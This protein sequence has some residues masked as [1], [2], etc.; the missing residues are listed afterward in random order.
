MAAWL[1]CGFPYEACWQ[2]KTNSA[3]PRQSK[4]GSRAKSAGPKVGLRPTRWLGQQVW[5]SKSE[6]ISNMFTQNLIGHNLT[7]MA[8]QK[9]HSMP[10]DAEFR[11][12]SFWFPPNHLIFRPRAQGPGAPNLV[13]RALLGPKFGPPGPQ[14]P[15][16]GPQF[17]YLGPLGPRGPPG[18]QFGPL[19]PLG[20][21]WVPYWPLWVPYWPLWAPINSRYTALRPQPG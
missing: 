9:M 10:K 4:P 8:P 19:G 6:R 18:P 1:A 16:F 20:A 17:N 15:K 21:L 3:E 2:G 11:C 7:H 5:C 13:P 14:G 12:G